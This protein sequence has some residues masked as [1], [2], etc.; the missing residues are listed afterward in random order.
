MDC[1]HR[2]SVG[3]G[4]A[5]ELRGMT[6]HQE[7]EGFVAVQLT[8][9]VP[10]ARWDRAQRT[11]G[12]VEL[13]LDGRYHQDLI[14]VHGERLWTY[15]RLLGLL[16]PGEHR[17]AVRPRPDAPDLP[18]AEITDLRAVPLEPRD[19]SHERALRE[20]PVLYLRNE[21]DPWESLYSDTPLFVFYRTT[22]AGLEWQCVFSHEDEGTDTRAL[23]ALWGRTTDIEWVLRAENDAV[24]FHG[25]GHRTLRHSGYRVMGRHCLQVVGRHGMVS[26]ASPTGRM[27][28]LFVP[29]WEWDDH[30]PRE[31][32]M[33]VEP[34]SYRISAEE[35]LRHD[36]VRP[37]SDARDPAPGDLRDYAFLQIVRQ[38]AMDGPVVGMEVRIDTMDGAV[39]SS[40]HGSSAL[41]CTRPIPFSTTVKLPVGAVPRRIEAVAISR[42]G[43]PPIRLQL[44]QAFRLDRDYQ[45]QPAFARGA[46]VVLQ[47]EDT[48]VPLWEVRHKLRP[49]PL[50]QR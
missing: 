26:S 46:A 21:G 40:T 1:D 34:W 42:P 47:P 30:L 16:P 22:P 48:A 31:T 35:V 17:I 12:L 28:C 44:H 50:A 10:G 38:P 37:G 39:F 27:R 4:V 41:A 6:W 49:E 32:C 19:A 23:L 7:R 36:L 13:M 5:R 24:W 3:P 18:P 29:R 8:A 15:E 9:T 25:P 2:E 20:A 43:R 45:P 11:C 33:D 14:L